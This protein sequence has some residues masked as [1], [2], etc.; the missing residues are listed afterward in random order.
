MNPQ[1]QNL[2]L[3]EGVPLPNSFSR[4]NWSQNVPEQDGNIPYNL[5]I[6]KWDSSQVSLIFFGMSPSLLQ[7]RYSPH[8][9][10]RKALKR[11]GNPKQRKKAWWR[12]A[13]ERVNSKFICR[14]FYLWHFM[15]FDVTKHRTKTQTW[16]FTFRQ[17]KQT[18][19]RNWFSFTFKNF[20]LR[21]GLSRMHMVFFGLLKAKSIKHKTR[22]L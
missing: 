20:T 4:W 3:F 9:T 17:F 16:L 10:G 1:T 15:Q 22:F 8:V 13:A 19:K 2:V 6:W 12:T 21:E 18:L 14:E 5:P 7:W 11:R